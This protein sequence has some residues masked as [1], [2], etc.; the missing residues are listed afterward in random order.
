MQRRLLRFTY[1]FATCEAPTSHVN[2]APIAKSQ[3]GMPHICP[4]PFNEFA[5]DQ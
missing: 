4:T 3:G 2:L 5:Y 1:P